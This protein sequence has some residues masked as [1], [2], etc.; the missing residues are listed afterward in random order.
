MEG[1]IWRWMGRGGGV[2]INVHKQ[3]SFA[4]DVRFSERLYEAQCFQVQ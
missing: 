2:E 3:D 1:S 4:R